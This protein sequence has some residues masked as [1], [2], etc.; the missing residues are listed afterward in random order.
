MALTWYS[1]IE[2][3]RKPVKSDGRILPAYLHTH[4][5]HHL[6]SGAR[7]FCGA[8]QRIVR[9]K[10]HAITGATPSIA[11]ATAFWR[12]RGGHSIPL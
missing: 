10:D 6:F 2:P 9:V 4:H 8:Y 5:Q 1:P 7:R 11:T 3:W 12:N